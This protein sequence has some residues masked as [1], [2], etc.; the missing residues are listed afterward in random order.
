MA[1][2]QQQYVKSS[3]INLLSKLQVKQFGLC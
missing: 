3:M 1:A 2:L